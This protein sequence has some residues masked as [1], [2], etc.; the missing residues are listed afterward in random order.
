VEVYPREVGRPVE[1]AD[2]HNNC[3]AVVFWTRRQ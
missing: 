2:L 1:F 3:G